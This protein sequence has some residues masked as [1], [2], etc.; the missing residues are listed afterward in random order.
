MP[1]STVSWEY[2]YSGDSHAALSEIEYFSAR[3]MRRVYGRGDHYKEGRT[4][5]MDIWR[6]RDNRLLVRFWGRSDDVDDE[7][8]EIIGVPDAH[9]LSGPPFD[10]RW[11]PECLRRQY[12]MWVIVNS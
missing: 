8:W 11:V 3:G 12:D 1:V 10:E 4:F 5:N 6:D 7:S 9:R 2:A